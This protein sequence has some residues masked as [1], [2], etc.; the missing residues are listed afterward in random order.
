MKAVDWLGL[1]ETGSDRVPVLNPFPLALTWVMVSVAVPLLVNC[2]VCVLGEPTTT[3][4]KLALEGVMFRPA[5]TPLPVTGMTALAP[6]ELVTVMLPETF[7]EA[8]GLNEILIEVFPPAANVTGVEI[9]LTAKSVAFTVIW[10]RV[11]L[12]VPL[13]VMVTFWER[14][15][16]TFTP[17]MLRLAGFGVSV[18]EAAVPV[19]LKATALGELGALLARLTLPAKLPAVVGANKTVKVVLP[20]AA[21]VAGVTNPLTL[22]P[23]PVTES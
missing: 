11:T 7:S 20:P 21:T 13:L 18:T 1:S 5:C 15:L 22:Y 16:P 9:P 17:V 12:V 2:I 23:L 14:E 19:P 10:E 4:P 3:L 6:C 8:L